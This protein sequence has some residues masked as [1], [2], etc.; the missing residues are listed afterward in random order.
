MVEARLNI[1]LPKS[2]INQV[3]KT[4]GAHPDKNIFDT[5]SRKDCVFESLINWDRSRK[6]NIYFWLDNIKMEN[7]LPFGKD[8]F[9]NLICF[10]FS[11]NRNPKVVFW[12]H[13]NDQITFIAD[14]FD[15]FLQGLR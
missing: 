4:N 15:S 1:S 10:D 7:I 2:Y 5:K 13:E 8:P 11:S 14:S 6:A 9:G 3:L 12:D